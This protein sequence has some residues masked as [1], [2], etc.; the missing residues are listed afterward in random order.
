[1]KELIVIHAISLLIAVGALGVAVWT[2][3][4]GTIA[5]EGIDGLFLIAVCLFL[6][7][8][9]AV[10]PVQAFRKGLWREFLKARKGGSA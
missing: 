3:L 5:R 7:G 2:L 9:F 10:L 8:V 1:M 4:S 6:A